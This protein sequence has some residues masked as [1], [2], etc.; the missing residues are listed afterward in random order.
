MG[1]LEA[2]T[3][4][5]S[6]FRS[7]FVCVCGLV[8]V[9][10]CTFLFVFMFVCVRQLDRNY[11]FGGFCQLVLNK[12]GEPHVYPRAVFVFV[13]VFTFVCVRCN[14]LFWRLLQA[15]LEQT[16]WASCL[17]TCCSDGCQVVSSN[18]IAILP[19]IVRMRMISPKKWK[20]TF[21]LMSRLKVVSLSYN[22]WVEIYKTA[23]KILNI[24]I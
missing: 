21:K 5:G 9:F 13:I 1:I 3:G 7:T 22:N 2:N 19:F 10:V 15:C 24:S 14:W 8:F 23:K 16:R 4:L 12:H 17:P 11:Y 6:S 20:F 18:V